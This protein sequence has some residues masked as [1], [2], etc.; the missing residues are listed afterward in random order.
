MS[1][2]ATNW[3]IKQRGIRPAAKIVLWQLCYRYHPD[4]GCFP[5]LETLANDCEMSRRSV[6]D[7]IDQLVSVGLVAVEKMPRRAGGLP[8]N[9]YRFAFEVDLG[10]ILPW[11]NSALGKSTSPPWAN[12]RKNLGQNLPTN[13]VREQLREPVR[14]GRARKDDPALDQI[15]RLAGLSKENG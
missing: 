9:S 8:R 5:S 2:D 6:Q 14:R 13:V 7:Q 11:A 12:S 15:A 10:Q 1:Y 4:N 3:A